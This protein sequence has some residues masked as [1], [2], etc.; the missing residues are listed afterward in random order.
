MARVG[1]GFR[2]SFPIVDISLLNIKD[3]IIYQ[4]VRTL[5]DLALYPERAQ[6]RVHG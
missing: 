3:P 6:V 5:A 4:I 1:R 2:Y